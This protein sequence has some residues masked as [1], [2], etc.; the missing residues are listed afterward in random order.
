MISVTRGCFPLRHTVRLP[1]LL[2]MAIALL[3]LGAPSPIR[4][5]HV[6]VVAA[7]AVLLRRRNVQTRQG[8]VC[9]FARLCGTP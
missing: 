6:E 4:T 7:G 8:E 5:G 2:A 1:M 3:L 9:A